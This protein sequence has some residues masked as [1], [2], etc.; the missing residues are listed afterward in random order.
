M[1]G[2]ACQSN[3]SDRDGINDQVDNCLGKPNADQVSV[4]NINSIFVWHNWRK[5]QCPL[6]KRKYDFDFLKSD[7]K[8]EVFFVTQHHSK[9]CY[10]LNVVFNLVYLTL[11]KLT[12]YYN[13]SLSRHEQV[14]LSGLCFER[15]ISRNITHLNILVHDVINL[16]YYE[17]WTDKQKYFY[18][19]EDN[20]HL[21]VI[22]CMQT[23]FLFAN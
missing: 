10:E 11:R 18:V 7:S 4:F 2:D 21:E 9:N 19:Y 1:V 12:L 15:S 6:G 16:L 5:H 20:A 14:C 22:F 13:M 23:A 17:Y 3:D 8:Q